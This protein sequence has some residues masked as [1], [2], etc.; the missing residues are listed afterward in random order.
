MLDLI[1]LMNNDYFVNLSRLD[2]KTM[3]L[4]FVNKELDHDI[5]TSITFDQLRMLANNLRSLI[6]CLDISVI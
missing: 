5:Y 1:D 6:K 3:E 2:N 4:C